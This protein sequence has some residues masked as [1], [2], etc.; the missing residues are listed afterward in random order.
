MALGVG[1]VGAQPDDDLGRVLVREQ[2]AEALLGRPGRLGLVED[3]PADEV[4]VVEPWER[5]DAVLDGDL[6]ELALEPAE[7]L[8]RGG[9]GGLLLCRRC[10]SPLGGRPRRSLPRRSGRLAGAAD[11]PLQ[12]LLDAGDAEIEKRPRSEHG[13][14]R[15]KLRD[16][17]ADRRQGVL[18]AMRQRG[19]ELGAAREAFLQLEERLQVL[20]EDELPEILL[21]QD[22]HRLV[23]ELLV[24]VL[25]RLVLG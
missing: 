6:D 16:L 4:G 18:V 9:V 1:H 12:R 25:G 20:G 15:A 2:I 19:R 21:R 10:R 5:G 7:H 3:H 13:L 17:I 11:L 24:E 23:A 14:A 22:D 8:L